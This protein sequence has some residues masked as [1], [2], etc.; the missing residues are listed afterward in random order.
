MTRAVKRR[1]K[2]LAKKAVKKSRGHSRRTL[3]HGADVAP[4]PPHMEGLL[5]GLIKEGLQAFQSGQTEKAKAAYRQ[6]L[7]SDPDHAEANHMMS[8]FAYR[9]GDFENVIDFIKR[10]ISTAPQQPIYY[11]N[12]GIA[13]QNLDRLDEAIANYQKALDLNPAYADAHNNLGTAFQEMERA[14]DAIP[15]FQKALALKTDYADAHGNMGCALQELGRLDEARASYLKALSINPNYAKALSNLGVVLQVTGRLDDAAASLR[16]ALSIDP[17]DVKAHGNM[18]CVL[19]ELGRMDEALSSFHKALDLD[20][21]NADT[22]NN[23]GIALQDMGRLDEACASYQKALALDPGFA[24]AHSNLI[25]IQDLFSNMDQAAQQAE[26]KRWD[27]SFIR[28]LSGKIKPHANSRDEGRRLRIGY[29]S[30]DFRHHSACQGFAP[31]ILDH[32]REQFEVV[33]YDANAVPDSITRDLRTAATSWRATLGVSDEDL[34]KMIRADGIDI[35]VDLS[36]HT[37][38]ARLTVFGY[39]PAPVQVTGVGH[40]PPG[41][42]TID[43][44]LTTAA[45]TPPGEEAIIPEKPIYLETY[46]GFRAPPHAPQVKP[47]GSGP[48][49]FGCFNRFTKISDQALALWA[50][51]LLDTPESRLLIKAAQ[52]SEAPLRQGIMDFFSGHGIAKDRLILL[53]KTSHAEHLEAYNRVDVSLDTFPQGGGITT[54][55]SLWM[56]T[57]VVG[58]LDSLK[59]IGRQIAFTCR[60]LGLDAWIAES[61]E[62][63]HRIAV[64]WAGRRQELAELGSEMRGRIEG[65]YGRFTRD[66]EDAYRTIWKRWRNDE[67]P[68]PL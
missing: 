48:M 55:E 40:M 10:A 53:S 15:C 24:V 45:A 14:G 61:T 43:Y 16:Q 49:T 23:L 32:D 33:C 29:V 5:A 34:A 21:G 64:E 8:V 63:Y 4:A 3:E 18:G 42:S 30:A 7:E 65:V 57:P 1:Q 25:F 27:D 28:P 47:P 9:D 19:N 46:F 58:L 59:I 50:R 67:A 13:F 17:H 51:I 35:L 26:R 60:P 36:G 66:V 20:P 68:S 2:K 39:K 54:L 44:R 41:L 6:V 12:L 62:D 38:G 11:N 52:M 22:H 56:G 37:K 31:L